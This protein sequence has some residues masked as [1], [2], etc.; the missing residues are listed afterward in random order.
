MFFKD[1]IGQEAAKE[2]LLGEIKDGRIPHARLIC[3]PEGTGKFP[4]ALAYARYISCTDQEENDACGKC[5]SCV[6]F[7]KLVHPDVHFIFPIVKNVKRKKEACNDYIAEWRKFIIANPYFNLNHW[8]NEIGANNSQAI[9]YAKESDEILKK[10]S[11]K[12]SENGYKSVFIW[13]PEKMHPVCA[14]KLLKLLE[15][16][17]EKTLFLLI[18][19]VPEMVLSTILSRTQRFNVRK[20]EEEYIAETLQNKFGVLEVDSLSIAHLSN[21]NFIKALETIHLNEENQLFF[22]LFINLMRLSYQ[23]KIKEMKQWSEQLAEMGRERQKNFLNYCQRMIRENFIY[24]LHRK[25][26]VYM[27]TEEQNFAIRFAPFINE[28]NITGIMQELDEA[29]LHIEKNVNS[30]MVFFDFSLKIIVLLKQ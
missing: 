9:I 30:K 25:E 11:L 28:R 19:E 12:S 5:P 17:P 20:I 26:M 10:L 4:L 1:V 22:N 6:K 18:S 14:N 2:R 13:L 27:T 16:P 24:N 23:R 7:N 15:E 8:L 29:Q 3:G 21:G